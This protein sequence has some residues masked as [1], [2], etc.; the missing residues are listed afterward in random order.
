M[1]GEINT[2]YDYQLG[3]ILFV[4]MVGILLNEFVGEEFSLFYLEMTF[5]AMAVCLAVKKD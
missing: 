3:G 4:T 2:E 1:K 5:L